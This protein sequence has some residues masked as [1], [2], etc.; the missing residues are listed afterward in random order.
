MMLIVDLVIVGPTA[1]I[2]VTLFLLR[3]L[4]MSLLLECDHLLAL[5]I[6]V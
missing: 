5:T 1:G 6:L 4:G 3:L 2:R